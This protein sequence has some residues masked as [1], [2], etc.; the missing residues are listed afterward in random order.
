M[1]SRALQATESR[2]R[3]AYSILRQADFDKVLV[4]YAWCVNAQNVCLQRENY[5][6]STGNEAFYMALDFS[7][8][9]TVNHFVVE[10]FT[11]VS[12]LDQQNNYIYK[13]LNKNP[14]FNLVYSDLFSFGVDPYM[15]QDNVKDVRSMTCELTAFILEYTEDGYTLLGKETVASYYEEA[16][17]TKGLHNP[18]TDA[19]KNKII[20]AACEFI[21]S[22]YPEYKPTNFNIIE[23][24]KDL[25]EL[26]RGT[27]SLS[28]EVTYSELFNFL[29][30]KYKIRFD[31][32]VDKDRFAN[33][34]VSFFVNEN[35][36]IS[37]GL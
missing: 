16:H 29:S 11:K 35:V 1:T 24:K 2:L 10:K 8:G 23:N 19:Q 5:C 17:L 21:V 4:R 34:V 15:V 25:L 13:P 26:S 6:G 37:V 3:R 33:N 28:L 22:L 9:K 18:N 20:N 14:I 7:I 32:I 31:Q 30:H 27:D 36:Y 12:L